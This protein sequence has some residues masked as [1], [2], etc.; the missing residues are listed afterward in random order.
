VKFFTIFFCL[1]LWTNFLALCAFVGAQS[2]ALEPVLGAF[3]L[4]KS[5]ITG[6]SDSY[7]RD[8]YSGDICPNFFAPNCRFL[9]KYKNI[10]KAIV[11]HGGVYVHSNSLAFTSIR[12]QIAKEEGYDILNFVHLVPTGSSKSFFIDGLFHAFNDDRASNFYAS[13]E[14]LKDTGL[15]EAASRRSKKA[16][17]TICCT[18]SKHKED[19]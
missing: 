14:W 17:S 9:L 4:K 12:A 10:V 13:F 18:E 16:V 5:G 15:L 11:L 19:S 3:S 2:G 8:K 6:W 7:S 1:A